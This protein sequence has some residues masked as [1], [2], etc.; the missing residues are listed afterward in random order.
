MHP[1]PCV[2][3]CDLVPS[4]GGTKMCFTYRI[5]RCEE[6]EA[7]STIDEVETDFVVLSAIVEVTHVLVPIPRAVV[8]LLQCV[9]VQPHGEAER[10]T[11]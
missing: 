8:K 1:A 7:Q 6:F 9:E 2:R 5:P 3:F 10:G 4:I 11:T